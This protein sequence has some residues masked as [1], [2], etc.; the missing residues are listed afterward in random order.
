MNQK[1]KQ[2]TVS[3][4]RVNSKRKLEKTKTKKKIQCF[5]VYGA[6][7]TWIFDFLTNKL[8]Q[9]SS[10]LF[11]ASNLRF[12]WERK[13]IKIETVLK[14]RNVFA[15]EWLTQIKVL[16]YGKNGKFKNVKSNLNCLICWVIISAY[17]VALTTCFMWI[18]T[19]GSNRKL[20]RHVTANN[21]TSKEQ[22]K[23]AYLNKRFK[24]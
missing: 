1:K 13:T 9:F 6:L 16:E 5:T 21:F 10:L 22:F 18:W 2:R 3:K 8:P 23:L 4:R 17:H 14:N 24:Q 12:R 19:Y 15:G 11:S 20:V 7:P